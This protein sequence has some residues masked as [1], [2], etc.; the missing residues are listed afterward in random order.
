MV[1]MMYMMY[2]VYTYILFTIVIF[3]EP[4][5]EIPLSLT[6]VE[7]SDSEENRFCV[8]VCAYNMFHIYVCEK[9]EK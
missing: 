2:L 9:C 1:S 8:C 5:S 7:M 3:V 6:C 4:E